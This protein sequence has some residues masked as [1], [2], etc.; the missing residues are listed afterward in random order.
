MRR[1]VVLAVLVLA[2]FSVD[3]Q[4]MEI[5]AL[6]GETIVL[7]NFY[8]SDWNYFTDN[9]TP[10]NY[11]LTFKFTM[12]SG[13]VDSVFMRNG[14]VNLR[15][16]G[17]L[18]KTSST[19]AIQGEVKL[20]SRQ[21]KTAVYTMII[22]VINIDENTVSNAVVDGNVF[23]L[24]WDYKSVPVAFDNFP[25]VGK[26]PFVAA[27]DNGLILSTSFSSWQRP[28]YFG[29]DTQIND[30]IMSNYNSNGLI[31][32]RFINFTGKPEL[33]SYST[34]TI[35][36]KVY[37]Y[38]YEVTY[39][40]RLREVKGT[41]NSIT[42]DYT[43]QVSSLGSYCIASDKV[44][45]ALPPFTYGPPP[46]N[47]GVASQSSRPTSTSISRPQQSSTVSSSSESTSQTVSS[48]SSN[49]SS[50]TQVLTS[51]EQSLPTNT[52]NYSENSSTVY[53]IIIVALAVLLIVAVVLA[54]FFWRRGR[55][56]TNW[57]EGDDV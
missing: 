18:S 15:I 40:N 31:D 41:Y 10:E 57:H 20:I 34:L 16:K 50:Q 29:H 11:R 33:L 2:V 48:S 54:I 1:I 43:F 39:G 24:P 26:S 5:T 6:P 17:T 22:G 19:K 13:Y 8:D 49:S 37:E 28:I 3:A 7:D 14:T 42:G 27:F 51:S 45:G 25:A 4:A 55:R 52:E 44:M 21:D 30:N 9:F 56:Y 38:V 53:I 23:T 47:S 46:P 12:G 36:K 35:P 32:M